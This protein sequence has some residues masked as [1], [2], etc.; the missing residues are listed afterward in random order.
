VGRH[1]PPPRGAMSVIWGGAR[2][3]GMRDIFTLNEIWTQDKIYILVGI[4]LGLNLHQS[5]WDLLI[6]HSDRSLNSE[7][8][9]RD[10][11]CEK[12]RSENVGGALK[13]KLIFCIT[14]T[15]HEPVH[16]TNEIRYS[17]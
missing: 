12:K 15:T 9:Q 3:V 5:A 2:V 17:T 8:F 6:L 1:P 13:L 10:R 16:S 11:Y 4:L 7:H 14:D